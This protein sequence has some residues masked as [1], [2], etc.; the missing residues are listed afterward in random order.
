MTGAG[1]NPFETR[2]SIEHILRTS[3]PVLDHVLPGLL[4]GSAGMI[5]GPGGVGK[6]ML[7]L[8][9]GMALASGDPLCGGLFESQDQGLTLARPADKVVLVLAEESVGII[10]H[11]LHAI[12]AT[13]AGDLRLRCTQREPMELLS[14]WAKNLHIYPMAGSL[15]LHVMDSMYVRTES[16][17]HLLAACEGARLVV[18]DPIRQFHPCDENDSAAMTALVQTLHLLAHRTGAAVV[19]AHHTNRAS[20]NLGLGDTAGASRGSTALTDGVR[21]QLNLST[22]TKEAARLRGIEEQDR[23]RYMLVDIAKS[24]YLAPQKTALLERLAGGVLVLAEGQGHPAAT[25]GRMAAGNPTR[26]RRQTTTQ[27]PLKWGTV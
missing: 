25:G 3:P 8:Q 23:S 11:R 20:A 7:E 13:L 17:T 15:P 1:T 26:A 21:W 12:A 18:L 5:V 6:T 16:F 2:L 4:A 19:G 22:P 24:N 10:W 27:K 14:L 9:M